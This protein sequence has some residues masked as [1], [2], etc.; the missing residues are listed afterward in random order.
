MLDQN[1]AQ[2]L[3]WQCPLRTAVCQNPMRQKF[4]RVPIAHVRPVRKYGLLG[5]MRAEDVV[6]CN[7]RRFGCHT[8]K[9]RSS[10]ITAFKIGPALSHSIAMRPQEN[11][12][13]ETV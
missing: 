4:A 2:T 5:R 12:L 3:N 1:F 9:I 10:G 11:A 6:N 8:H 13:S 7:S